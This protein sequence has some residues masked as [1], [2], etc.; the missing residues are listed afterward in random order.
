MTVNPT[1]TPDS[2]R[3]DRWLWATRF[4]KTRQTAVSAIRGG[5]VNVNG[6]RAKPAK[7]IRV[8]DAVTIQRGA[9]RYCL[10]ISN[11]S[12]CRRSAAEAQTLYVET[13]ESRR[14]RGQLAEQMRAN[15]ALC[16]AP[17]RRPT[18]RDR[19]LLTRVQRGF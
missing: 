15:G 13:D 5:K 10:I 17:Q 18:K 11:L 12:A 6:V 7:T 3:L 2:A 8:G 9:F 4:F 19:R 14:R 1:A 16:D